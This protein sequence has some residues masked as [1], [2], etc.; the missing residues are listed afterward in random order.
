[1]TILLEK[2]SNLEGTSLMEI[3]LL[4]ERRD[5]TLKVRWKICLLVGVRFVSLSRSSGKIRS[6]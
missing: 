3:F 1:M 6:V 5:L 4:E 2:N